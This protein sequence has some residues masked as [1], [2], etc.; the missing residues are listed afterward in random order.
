MPRADGPPTATELLRVSR[1]FSVRNVS[2]CPRRP[3]PPARI[4]MAD[5]R[6]RRSR[7]GCGRARR[8][9]S[10]CPAREFP[11]CDANRGGPGDGWA[12]VGLDTFHVGT[13]GRQPDVCARHLGSYSRTDVRWAAADRRVQAPSSDICRR[14]APPWG[15]ATRCPVPWP[16]C[17]SSASALERQRA[18][19]VRRWTPPPRVRHQARRRASPRRLGRRRPPSERKRVPRQAR[20]PSLRPLPPHAPLRPVPPLRNAG[21]PPPQAVPRNGRRMRRRR[22]CAPC[23]RAST[24]RSPRAK[25]NATGCVSRA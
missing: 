15:Q 3:A 16:H 10:W 13:G 20:R 2:R 25:P 22:N 23:D 1:Q 24:G 18:R 19:A 21:S 5:K 7:P 14:N 9:L 6:H 4:R 11:S 8:G 12:P 17:W